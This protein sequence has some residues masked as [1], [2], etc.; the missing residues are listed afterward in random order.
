MLSAISYFRFQQLSCSESWLPTRSHLQ[1][2]ATLLPLSS[3]VVSLSYTSL[4]QKAEAVVF[5]SWLLLTPAP[6][7][8]STFE[9]HLSLDSSLCLQVA[10]LY[11]YFLT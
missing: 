6:L 7:S 11:T 2:D 1:F 4:A 3:L 10:V 8:S 9:V 5:G